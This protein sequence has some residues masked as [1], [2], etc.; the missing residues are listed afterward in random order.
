MADQLIVTDPEDQP[1]PIVEGLKHVAQGADWDPDLMVWGVAAWSYD[2]G[3]LGGW[4]WCT[5][6]YT[7]LL[8]HVPGSDDSTPRSSGVI[9]DRE[10]ARAAGVYT[11]AHPA[12]GPAEVFLV[13]HAVLTV[14]G[15]QA[16]LG[17]FGAFDL[18]RVRQAAKWTS[19]PRESQLR[20]GASKTASGA[21]MLHLAGDNGRY[22]A[23]AGIQVLTWVPSITDLPLD[24]PLEDG[25][26]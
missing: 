24:G 25:W 2:V 3:V 17:N 21:D 18:D 16:R 7:A 8:E 13:D 19:G 26:R 23:V 20:I 5:D 10:F 12:S 6:R 14:L 22:A 9:T 15:G 4:R 11:L 1:R